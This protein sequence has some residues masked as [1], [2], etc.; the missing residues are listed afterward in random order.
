MDDFNAKSDNVQ[1]ESEDNNIE[2]GEM[3]NKN[4]E[5]S[6]AALSELEQPKTECGDLMTNCSSNEDCK[7]CSDCPNG[8]FCT[9]DVFSFCECFHDYYPDYYEY[10]NG[11]D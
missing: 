2:I 8:A 1:S 10:D 7:Q 4:L 9:M 3:I 6:E 5:Y 11:L